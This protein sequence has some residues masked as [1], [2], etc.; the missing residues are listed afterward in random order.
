MP[1]AGGF[2]ELRTALRDNIKDE[3]PT[4]S[5]STFIQPSGPSI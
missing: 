4:L 1:K 2:V 5:T 3:I